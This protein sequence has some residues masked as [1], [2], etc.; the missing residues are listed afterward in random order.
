[1][2][3]QTVVMNVADIDRSLAFYREVLGFAELAKKDQLAAVYAAGNE[4]PQ[5]VVFREVQTSGRRSGAGHV[6]MRALVLEV[7]SAEELDRVSAAL[8]SGGYLMARR[9]GPTW[10]A[11]FGR[12]PDGTAVAATTSKDDKPITLEA[13][14]DLDEALYGIAE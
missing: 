1:M 4:H 3:L 5:V 9:E 6:G 14:A 13:W 10:L 12:D 11:A 7:D 2:N 8:E